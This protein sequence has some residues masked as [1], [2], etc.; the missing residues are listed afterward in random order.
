MSINN[1]TGDNEQTVATLL[2][3]M[4]Q[5]DENLEQ[6]ENE[7]TK[8]DNNATRRFQKI[9][10][11]NIVPKT[12][13]SYQHSVSKF[14]E[15]IFGTE[16][17]TILHPDVITPLSLEALKESPKLLPVAKSFVHLTSRTFHPIDLSELTVQDFVTFLLS[18]RPEDA[19]LSKSSYGTYRSGL[20]NQFRESGKVITDEF[21]RDLEQSFA[22]LKRE[23]QRFKAKNG[24]KL[25]E[26]K[27]PLPFPLYRK[28]CEW[29]IEDGSKEAIFSGSFL[30]LT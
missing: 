20:F 3:R 15:W 5:E 13:A 24:G 28:L 7:V 9:L 22:G 29:M 6:A 2:L 30:T 16:R 14:V 8:Q 27:N 25:G 4:Q 19:F 12:R 18:L 1:L 23:S 21:E 17:W 26:G 11:S 10:R